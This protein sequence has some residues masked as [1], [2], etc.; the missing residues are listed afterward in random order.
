MR[1]WKLLA[2]VAC[3]ALPGSSC[4]PETEVIELGIGEQ[5]FV[6]EVARTTEQ[7]GTGLMHRKSLAPHRGMLFVYDA[8]HQL[9]FWMKDT[10]IPLSIAFLSSSGKITEIRD[11]RPRSLDVLSSRLAC[12]Y[13]LEA[14]LGAFAE[15]GVGEG[16]T[17]RFPEGFR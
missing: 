12:R 5:V 9:S 11:M 15:A 14:N 3:A 2:L 6:V 13:A 10:L 8:D 4:A 1:R 7:Q 17:I 16:D